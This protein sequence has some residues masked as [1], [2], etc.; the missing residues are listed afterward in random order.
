MTLRERAMSI[1]NVSILD[2]NKEAVTGSVSGSNVFAPVRLNILNFA[3][4]E[5]DAI[6]YLAELLHSDQELHRVTLDVALTQ[7]RRTSQFNQKCI[8]KTNEGDIC[9]WQCRQSR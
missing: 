2:D 1:G 3:M 8:G 4:R 6:Y 7:G 9:Q 5:G